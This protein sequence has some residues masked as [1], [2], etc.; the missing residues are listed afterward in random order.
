MGLE[1][2][3]AAKV[4]TIKLENPSLI[5]AVVLIPVVLIATD[6]NSRISISRT[7]QTWPY[8]KLIKAITLPKQRRDYGRF[9]IILKTLTATR[10]L[11]SL[12]INGLYAY[13]D[14]PH[15]PA[16]LAR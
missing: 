3:Q 13:R 4:K 14:R 12:M 16:P 10:L 7:S 2:A 6:C 9:V 11:Q 1:V 15:N 5:S 8:L